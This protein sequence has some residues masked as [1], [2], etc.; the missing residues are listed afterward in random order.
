MLTKNDIKK[1]GMNEIKLPGL[2]KN[3]SELND[4]Q[5]E[6]A[7]LYDKRSYCEMYLSFLLESQIIFETFCTDN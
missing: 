5:Y 2:L 3:D 1:F 7:I 6:K 4:M